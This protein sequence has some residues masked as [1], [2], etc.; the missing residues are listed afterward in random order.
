MK[1]LNFLLIFLFIIR[2][3]LISQSCLSEG[4]EFTTQT[5]IDS[6]QINYPNCTEIEGDLLIGS[7]N[8]NATITNL[9]SLECLTSIGGRLDIVN[10]ENLMNLSG[11]GNVSSIGDW[12]VIYTNNSL[13]DLSGLQSIATIGNGLAIENNNSITSLY[14]LESLIS[15]GGQLSINYNTNLTNLSGLNSL[16][17]INGSLSIMN[18]MNLT[19][20]SGI[21]NLDPTSI[22]EFLSIKYNTSLSNCAIYGICNYIINPTGDISINNNNDGCNS[23]TEVELACEELS[24]DN[25]ISEK[26]ISVFPN[27]ANHFLT[28]RLKN[29][30]LI[31]QINI[32]NLQ[33]RNML[34]IN[35]MNNTIDISNIEKGFYILKLNYGEI[36]FNERLIIE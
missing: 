31:D 10:C 24:V 17:E 29:G 23:Q 30:D 22:N 16:N 15:V 8:G 2:T 26:N 12:L 6:F 7:W 19:D 9:D 20:I 35:P 5:A 33:G 32:Y 14:G 1:K 25:K 13:I 28:V 11:L 27:P 18:N 3:T 4:I 36:E 34:S 21:E